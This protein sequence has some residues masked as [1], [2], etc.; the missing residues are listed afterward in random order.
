MSEISESYLKVQYSLRPCKQ[1]ERR[2]LLD[3]LLLISE[4]G[5]DIRSYTYMGMGS[6]HFVDFAMFHKYL[7]IESM[8]SV[9]FSTK[10]KKRIEFNNPYQNVIKLENGKEIGEIIENIDI[11][12]PYVLWLDYDNV[13]SDYMLRD[14]S[15][16]IT[17]LCSGSILLI[18]VDTEPPGT[19]EDGR[20]ISKENY[21]NRNVKEYFQ[22]IA[23]NYF[24][25]N[26]S[27]EYFDY[28]KLPSVNTHALLGA[29]R[30]GQ[31]NFSHNDCIFRP[32]FN[33][34]YADGHRMITIGG[35]ILNNKDYRTLKKS[36]ISKQNYVR[37]SF[38]EN[39]FKICIPCLTRREQ[40][41]LDKHMPLISGWKPN[42]NFELSEEDVKKYSEIYRYFPNYA[43]IYI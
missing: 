24:L 34:E 23:E 32:L 7:G 3:A 22:S 8:I 20:R 30:S 26:V 31:T 6:I 43:E 25:P 27:N 12:K 5:Y 13:L 14:I 42:K 2:M 1:V 19:L 21:N 40:L 17:K 39:P 11:H 38:D 10:I 28:D 33:F 18:T 29:I 37:W 16:A 36:R 9:E 4:A 41:F 35:I 15:L